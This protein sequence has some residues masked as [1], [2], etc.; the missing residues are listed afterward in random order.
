MIAQFGKLYKYF[1]VSARFIVS[2]ADSLC[3]RGVFMILVVLKL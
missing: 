2:F 1:F 3:Q